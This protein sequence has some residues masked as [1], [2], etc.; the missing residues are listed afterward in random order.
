[1]DLEL[2]EDDPGEYVPLERDEAGDLPPCPRCGGNRV[3]M[4]DDGPAGLRPC[5]YCGG[6]PTGYGSGR[7]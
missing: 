4:W 7:R 1:M 6:H 5:S 3:V 2:A